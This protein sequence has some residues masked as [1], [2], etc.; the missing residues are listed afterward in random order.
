[1][2]APT[3]AEAVKTANSQ[4]A[5]QVVSTAAGTAV[6]DTLAIVYAADSGNLAS[7]PD[8]TSTAGTL[9]P[10]GSSDAGNGNGH[11]KAYT[12]AVASSGSKDV[13]FPTFSGNDIFG[14]VLRISTAATSDASQ[15]QFSTTGT[16]SHVAPGVTTLGADRLLVCCWSPFSVFS[17]WTSEPYTVPGSMT[18]QAA[19]WASPFASLMVATEAVAASG[20]TGTRTATFFQSKAYTALTFALGAAGAAAV[21][22]P[23]FRRSRMGALLQV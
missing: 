10:V 11:I 2:P 1:M 9:T 14:A 15:S 4:T 19:V 16:T 7:M 17:S 21:S 12:V 5:T 22:D 3:V 20:A 8:A 23:P 13:T 6:G 18:A